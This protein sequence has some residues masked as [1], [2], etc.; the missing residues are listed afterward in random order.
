MLVGVHI[1]YIIPRQF[2]AGDT[3]CRK[4]DAQSLDAVPLNE[5]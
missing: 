4:Y 2:A 5:G 1:L 3:Y